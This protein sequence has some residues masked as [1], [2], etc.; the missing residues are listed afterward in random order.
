MMVLVQLLSSVFGL[1]PFGQT[2]SA[3]G[4]IVLSHNVV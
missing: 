4:G 1:S 3:V 2:V